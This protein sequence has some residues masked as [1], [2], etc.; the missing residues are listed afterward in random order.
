[1]DRGRHAAPQARGARMPYDRARRGE[2]LRPVRGLPVPGP[3]LRMLLAAAAAI[4]VLLAVAI[5]PRPGEGQA[6]DL[7]A[8]NSWIRIQHV[9]PAG[10]A[11]ETDFYTT[12]GQLVA[13]EECPA[14]T[15]DAVPP[16]S[17]WSF[18]QQTN[19]DLSPGYRGSGFVTVDQPFVALLARD[20]RRADGSFRIAGDTL[21]LASG[22]SRLVAPI[23]QNTEGYASR[24]S[25]ENVSD[26]DAACVQIAY[27]AEG[28]LNPAAVDPASPSSGCSQ[29]GER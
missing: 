4:L 18:F 3:R 28:Q 12:A 2:R 22:T 23:V 5:D 16:G 15:C 25:V 7:G 29:G 21:R 10:G 11:G 19:S 6:L 1:C 8:E 27:Y 20:V 14:A 17:G 24:I 9:G 26:S 13:T